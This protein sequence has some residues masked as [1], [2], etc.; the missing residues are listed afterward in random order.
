MEYKKLLLQLI[1]IQVPQNSI[2][3]DGSICNNRQTRFYIFFIYG[4]ICYIDGQALDA[5]S[6]GEFDEDTEYG[7]PL[8]YL[9]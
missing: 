1:Q 9:V 8:M 5:T 3:N 6:F 2:L 7:N 4:R